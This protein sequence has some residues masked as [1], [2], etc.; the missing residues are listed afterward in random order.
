[1]KATADLPA[2]ELIVAVAT[3]GC[4]HPRSEHVSSGRQQ[5]ADAAAEAI[6]ACATTEAGC[7]LCLMHPP[8]AVW[9][10]SSC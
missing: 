4:L 1:M 8:S 10:W 7:H 2:G 9:S 3:S 6:R 5:A